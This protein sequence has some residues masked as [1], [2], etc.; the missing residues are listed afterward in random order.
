M[1]KVRSIGVALRT[2]NP[3]YLQQSVLVGSRNVET[4][5]QRCGPMEILDLQQH[6]DL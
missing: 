3:L 4:A 6:K 2:Y 1:N 5:E